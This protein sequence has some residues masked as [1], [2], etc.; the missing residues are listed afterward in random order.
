MPSSLS[1]RGMI[2]RVVYHGQADIAQEL[3]CPAWSMVPA[4][5]PANKSVSAWCQ[6]VNGRTRLMAR[7]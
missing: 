5:G 4:T 6:V 1:Q 2:M 7:L 3:C